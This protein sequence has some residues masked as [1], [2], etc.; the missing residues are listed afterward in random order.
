MTKD[1]L[2]A[3]LR[4]LELKLHSVDVQDH[5]RT[6]DAPTRERFVAERIELS[7]MVGLLTHA[8]LATIQ[9]Q[10][11][12]LDVDLREGIDDLKQTLDELADTVAIFTATSRILGLVGRVLALV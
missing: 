6:Q 10:L 4:V 12:Q 1:E 7:R 3:A 9:Q 2:L 11:S 8:Q 5:F